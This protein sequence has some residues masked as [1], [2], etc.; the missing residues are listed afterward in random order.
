MNSILTNQSV[1]FL[2]VGF[3]CFYVWIDA[4]NLFTKPF[5]GIGGYQQAVAFAP[6]V[7]KGFQY[8]MDTI[9]KKKFRILVPAATAIGRA[10]PI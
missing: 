3:P 8:G 7:C 2:R 9:E 1:Q 6:F 10:S 4:G 5:Q